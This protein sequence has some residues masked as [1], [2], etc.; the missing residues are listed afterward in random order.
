[1]ITWPLPSR[2]YKCWEKVQN[3]KEYIQVKCPR[4]QIHQSLLWNKYYD[5]KQV[6]WN[7]YHIDNV[8]L[9]TKSF[10]YSLFGHGQ[11]YLF[12]LQIEKMVIN[13]M[14][15]SKNIIL[16]LNMK[17]DCSMIFNKTKKCFWIPPFLCVQLK[18]SQK[19]EVN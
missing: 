5:M 8:K 18:S 7:K 19:K 12:A 14:S 9:V 13:K 11:R 3:T 15:K 4:G 16:S 2:V 1:M 17:T 6:L 10:F